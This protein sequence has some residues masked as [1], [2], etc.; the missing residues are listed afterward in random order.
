MTSSK[1]CL[2]PFRPGDQ[3]GGG[4]R[5]AQ[6]RVPYCINYVK[7]LSASFQIWRF[8]NCIVQ[9]SSYL[10]MFSKFEVDD[11]W[12]G[13]DRS[14][15]S[16]PVN[17]K[18]AQRDTLFYLLNGKHVLLNVPTGVLP[19]TGVQVWLL[20]YPNKNFF[21]LIHVLLGYGK[22]LAELCSTLLFSNGIKST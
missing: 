8:W 11:R 14:N 18:T 5:Q 9:L 17:L 22:T 10:Q 20:V 12:A 7:I 13:L 6:W 4:Q 1:K 21:C 19:T 2:L 15:N 16:L 3:A